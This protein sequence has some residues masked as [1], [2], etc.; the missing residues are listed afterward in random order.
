M[1][2]LVKL[3]AQHGNVLDVV[4]HKYP[5]Y[6]PVLAM[7]ELAHREDVIGRD[8][9]LEF[10]IHKA[11]APYCAP[12]LSALEVRAPQ[13]PSRVIVSLFETM[14]L[15]NGETVEI[16]VPLVREIEEVVPLDS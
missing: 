14:A 3:Q 8:P 16:E 2:T 6:H 10:E 9:K 12:R 1:S 15:D 11:V 7:V 4:R 5:N 13:E